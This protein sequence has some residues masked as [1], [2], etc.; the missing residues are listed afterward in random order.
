M[1]PLAVILAAA[2]ALLAG[3]SRAAADDRPKNLRLAVQFVELPHR[4]LTALLAAKANSGPALHDQVMAVVNGGRGKVWESAMVMTRSGQKATIESIGEIL[5][6]TEFDPSYA[7]YDF[8]WQPPPE[9]PQP[10]KPHQRVRPFPGNGFQTH[11]AGLTFEVEPILQGDGRTIELWFEPELDTP[12]RLDTMLEHVDEWGDTSV[13][14][15]VFETWH[16]KSSVTLMAG[17]FEMVSVFTPKPNAPAPA[18]MRKIL[19]F[20]RADVVTVAPR[21]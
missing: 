15:P 14:M 17:Q 3:I 11:N 6:P 13:R 4:D 20:V 9:H 5:F 16:L 2:L 8:R 1:R 7:G 12:T 10:A 18:T 21:P 19:V